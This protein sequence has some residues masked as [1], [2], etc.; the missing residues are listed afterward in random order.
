MKNNQLPPL[1]FISFIK[2]RKGQLTKIAQASKQHREITFRGKA[3]G[4]LVEICE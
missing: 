3:G 2:I 4:R 1:L